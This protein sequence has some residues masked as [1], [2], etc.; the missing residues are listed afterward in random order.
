MI[1]HEDLRKADINTA[2]TGD[3]VIITGIAGA[4]IV[5]DHINLIPTTAVKVQLK[6]G[7]TN[8]GGPY[9]LDAK[10]AFVLDNNYDS[11]RGIIT[12]SQGEDF[13][14]NLESAVQVGGFVRYRVIGQ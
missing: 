10:Q 4:T 7:S 9:P 11:D 12:L 2:S 6:D 3:N 13:I 14:I 8:Y 5:I 1:F